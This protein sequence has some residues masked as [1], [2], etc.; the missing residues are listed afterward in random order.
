MLVWNWPLLGHWLAIGRPLVV[1]KQRAA[2]SSKECAW[3]AGIP[4]GGPKVSSAARE[5]W[6]PQ[7]L[8][9]MEALLRPQTGSRRLAAAD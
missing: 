4:K 8:G 6:R 5:C 9:P 1:Q 7:K 3:A 2:E